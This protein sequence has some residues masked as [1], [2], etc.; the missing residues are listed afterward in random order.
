MAINTSVLHNE[1][2]EAVVTALTE[3]YKSDDPDIP[4]PDPDSLRGFAEAIAS[5]A[6]ATAEHF[7]A[8]AETVQS[9]EG[10]Q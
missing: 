7:V 2:T 6:V 3:L 5:I 10:I 8:W 4:G 9:G 1:A